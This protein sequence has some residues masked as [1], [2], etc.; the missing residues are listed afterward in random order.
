LS[1]SIG[2]SM[3]LCVFA[4]ASVSV[5]YAHADNPNQGT[6]DYSTGLVPCSGP[7]CQA[8]SIVSLI[9]NI[10]NYAIGLSIPIA[11]ALF[12]WAGVLY[13]TESANP[14]GIE[15]AKKI[16][17]SALVGFIVAL[18]A[19]LIVDTILHSILDPKQYAEGSWFQIQCTGTG[20]TNG[21]IGTLLTS[22]LGNPQA[23]LAVDTTSGGSG[24]A[25]TVAISDPS[26]CTSATTAGSVSSAGVGDCSASSLSSFGT[27]ASTMSCILQAESTC[28]PTSVGDNGF[29]IGLAQI[30]ITANNVTC[31][32]TTYDCPTAFSQ[33]YTCN[34]SGVCT[35]VQVTNA[36]LAA[37]CK[38][39]LEDPSCNLQTAQAVLNTPR[40]LSNWSTY[41]SCQ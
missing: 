12:A 25:T 31:N 36:T 28:N 18:G 8:C 21:S 26:Q 1:L 33:P 7:D 29:S 19:Y 10:I 2:F 11:M 20:A 30:N 32:G 37:Q 23:P 40:G 6:Y 15:T 13:F 4:F 38:T 27:N 22:V 24:S 39:V 3:L 5:Q 41:S 16:F 14:H 34:K 9:Q 35:N 17:R